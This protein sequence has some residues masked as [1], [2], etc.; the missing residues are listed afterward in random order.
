MEQRENTLFFGWKVNIFPYAKNPSKVKLISE[1]LFDIEIQ[2]GSHLVVF[3]YIYKLAHNLVF[4]PTKR[5]E[6]VLGAWIPSCGFCFWKSSCGTSGETYPVPCKNLISSKPTWNLQFI[7]LKRKV[8]CGCFWGVANIN[9]EFDWVFTNSGKP[10]A[11]W[12]H[13]ILDIFALAKQA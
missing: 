9:F 7:P 1:N 13:W 12:I 6:K 8:I 10:L 11:M 3:G 4:S 2:G 5:Y